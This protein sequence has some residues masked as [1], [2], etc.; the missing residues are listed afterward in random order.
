[1]KEKHPMP[2]CV[3]MNS[4]GKRDEALEFLV[5]TS[6]K[7]SL[8]R[9]K[10]GHKKWRVRKGD[11]MC[12]TMKTRPNQKSA[13][14]NML[15]TYYKSGVRA[16]LIWIMEK[17]CWKKFCS[18]I[19]LKVECGKKCEWALKRKTIF[20]VWASVMKWTH[21][22][23]AI[24]ERHIKSASEQANERKNEMDVM[25]EKASTAT[26]TEIKIIYKFYFKRNKMCS[27]Q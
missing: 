4:V 18:R 5:S 11:T 12:R 14:E 9:K 25:N 20:R 23:N 17:N 3:P 8:K 2:T 7:D 26:L 1:M 6:R 22:V 13:I 16:I 10:S 15:A 21:R 27:K 19:E 24:T